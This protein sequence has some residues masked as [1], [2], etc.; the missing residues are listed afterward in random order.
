MK[1]L[2][3]GNDAKTVKGEKLGYL[4][5]ILYLVPDKKLCPACT[6]G[7]RKACLVSAGRGAFSNVYKARMRKTF[8]YKH[9]FD[10]FKK[11]LEDD[12]IELKKKADKKGFK[13]CVRINGTSDIDVEEVFGDI[14]DAH[15]DVQFYDYTKVWSRTATKE[16]Y[17]ICYSRSDKTSLEEVKYMIKAEKKNVAVVFNKVPEVWEGMTVVDGDKSDLR[18]LD[19]TGV[20]VGLK[21]KGK[22]RY[23]KSGFVVKV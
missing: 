19:G 2:S 14:L 8:V 5:G 3:V 1:L 21:A 22:A 6:A 7:C 16:N 18:F 10:V 17:F 9:R 4:T 20:I 15:K 23:D 13:A 11:Q 12:I